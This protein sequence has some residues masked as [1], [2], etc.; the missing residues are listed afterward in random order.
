MCESKYNQY[1]PQKKKCFSC[2]AFAETKQ[3][4]RNNLDATQGLK[5]CLRRK[6]FASKKKK[7]NN[8]I[9]THLKKKGKIFPMVP[10]QFFSTLIFFQKNLKNPADR[11]K[12]KKTLGALSKKTHHS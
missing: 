3:T 10:D 8:H 7:G 11:P 2:G 1:P 6:N 9:F 12:Q 5:Y 4:N